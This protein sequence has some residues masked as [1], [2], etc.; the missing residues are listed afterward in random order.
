MRRDQ[1]GATP[2]K[3]R[4]Q[5]ET[6]NVPR[7]RL[8]GDESDEQKLTAHKVHTA[9]ALRTEHVGHR[10]TERLDATVWGSWPY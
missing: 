7:I 1:P 9:S 6:G 2:V 8:E 3:V 5:V 4:S 10:R